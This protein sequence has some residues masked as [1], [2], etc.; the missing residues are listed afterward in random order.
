[1]PENYIVVYYHLVILRLRLE[2][3]RKYIGGIP[4]PARHLSGLPK[5]ACTDKKG[6]KNTKALD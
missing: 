3:I 6:V 2:S 4:L 5:L 1:L